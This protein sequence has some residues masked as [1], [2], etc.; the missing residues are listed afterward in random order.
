MNHKKYLSIVSYCKSWL[1]KYGDIH[2]DVGWTKKEEHA[3]TWYRVMLEMIKRDAV[4]QG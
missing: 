3:D 1:E 4:G 2:L